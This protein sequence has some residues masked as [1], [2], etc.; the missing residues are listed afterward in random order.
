MCG[1]VKG[2]G[3][4]KMVMNGVAG[5]MVGLLT[6]MTVVDIIHGLVLDAGI[7]EG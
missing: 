1:S 5:G 4:V 7:D 2:L 3:A 6:I